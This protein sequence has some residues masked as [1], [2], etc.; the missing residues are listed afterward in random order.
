MATLAIVN[1]GITPS[2]VAR[3]RVNRGFG[4]PPRFVIASTAL[5]ARLVARRLAS[6]T[7]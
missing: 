5:Y 7:R 1:R 3:R 6:R 4:R 2:P